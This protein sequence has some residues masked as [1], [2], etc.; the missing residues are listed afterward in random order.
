MINALEVYKV[1]VIGSGVIYTHGNNIAL[2]FFLSIKRFVQLLEYVFN[3]PSIKHYFK[4][5]SVNTLE[6]TPLR[7]KGANIPLDCS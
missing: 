5:K 1:F 2:H 3:Q 4:L 6:R 7:M